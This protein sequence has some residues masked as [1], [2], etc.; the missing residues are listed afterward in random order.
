MQSGQF[1]SKLLRK[2]CPRVFWKENDH[3]LTN[4]K[5]TLEP[6]V[7]RPKLNWLSTIHGHPLTLGPVRSSRH[8][9]LIE[10]SYVYISDSVRFYLSWGCVG[11]SWD[12]KNLMSSNTFHAVS[13]TLISNFHEKF[14]T[15]QFDALNTLKSICIHLP[16]ARTICY[17]AGNFKI[18][19]KKACH[20]KSYNS[21]RTTSLHF[22]HLLPSTIMP[23][24]HFEC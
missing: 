2:K 10:I 13:L 14:S 5:C 11:S 7:N 16:Q 22:S 12:L 15:G 6:F 9:E 24:F 18:I 1:F 3:F 4:M 20:R 19:C 23:S 8:W 21:T 17:C